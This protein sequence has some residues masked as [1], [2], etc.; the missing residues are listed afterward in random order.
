MVSHLGGQREEA[1]NKETHPRSLVLSSLQSTIAGEQD[2]YKQDKNRS[3]HKCPQKL[4]NICIVPY[5]FQRAF[6]DII[7]I[8]SSNRGLKNQGPKIRALWPGCARESSWRRGGINWILKLLF[9][10]FFFQW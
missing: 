4:I 10:N 9:N 8:N 3:A 2:T 6:T 7:S 1:G 5:S